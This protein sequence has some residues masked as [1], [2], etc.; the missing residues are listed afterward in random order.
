[1]LAEKNIE[2]FAQVKFKRIVTQ[3][4]H[5]Y[6]T[7]KNEYSQFG[8]NYQVLHYTELLAERSLTYSSEAAN[9]NGHSQ[10][11]TY[12]DP[13]YL[14]RHNQVFKQP[15]QLLQE[16]QRSPIEMAR[17]LENSMCCGGGGGQMW[18]ET[19]AETRINFNRLQDAL[20]CGAET[21]ATACPYCLLMFDDAIR[22]KGLS[23]KIQVL[24]IAEILEPLVR[25]GKEV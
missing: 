4:P 17:T 5:C 15:R 13:C 12:H 1:M 21:I 25:A 10:N 2:A 11:L 24:D 23:D 9:H 8:A 19:E 7:L 3:C 6:N 18:Q 14:G 20:D 22:S 16:A